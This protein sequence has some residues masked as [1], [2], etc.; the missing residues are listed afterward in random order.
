MQILTRPDGTIEPIGSVNYAELERLRAAAK[1]RRAPA[2]SDDKA[3]SEKK[4]E[5][6]AEQKS[7]GT[8]LK[9]ASVTTADLPTA[10]A[11][12]PKPATQGK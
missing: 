6:A 5:P 2:K 3:E 8:E 4:S 11:G 9:G 12:P 1:K 10:P 7:E